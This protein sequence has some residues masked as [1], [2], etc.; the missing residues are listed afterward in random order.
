M[1]KAAKTSPQIPQTMT[2]FRFTN[3]II[4][5]LALYDITPVSK[6]VLLYLSSCF[7]PKNQDVFPKQETIS[8]T[9]GISKR[10]VIRAIDDLLNAGLIMLE[11]KG[12]NRY[13]FTEKIMKNGDNLSPVLMCYD[14]LSP[15][16]RQNGTL[17]EDKLSPACHE[18]TIQPIKNLSQEDYDI[19]NRYMEGKDIKHK[20]SYLKKLIENGSAAKIIEWVRK[21]EKI[22]KDRKARE[23]AQKKHN[24]AIIDEIRQIAV[25]PYEPIL[26]T[27]E[28][29]IRHIKSLNP[30]FLKSKTI[31]NLRVRFSIT[32]NDLAETDGACM[33]I[34]GS[35]NLSP[36]MSNKTELGGAYAPPCGSERAR[37]SDNNSQSLFKSAF[38]YISQY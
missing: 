12:S 5:S 19:L 6:L 13:T 2:Q 29:A 3:K 10:S 18:Q 34:Q 33:Q 23:E 1:E 31:E 22:K 24:Q 25:T 38:N 26:D 8:S 15:Q 37:K 30:L 27:K 20:E 32:D 35:D 28:K 14:K 21:D 36:T 9:L 17:Q 7:N 4:N 11:R 16:T